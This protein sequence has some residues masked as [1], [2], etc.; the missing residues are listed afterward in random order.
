MGAESTP[1]AA[2]AWPLPDDLDLAALQ[3]RAGLRRLDARFL[4]ELD[5][6]APALAGQLRAARRQAPADARAE[7]ELLIELAG[8]LED[9]LGRL[10]A[11]EPEL[12]ALR[13]R[14]QA[15]DPVLRTKYKF[16]KR[17]ALLGTEPEQ[18][19]AFDAPALRTALIAAGADLADEPAFADALLQW[20]EQ[21][22]KGDDT[23]REVARARIALARDY[24][25]WAAGTEAGRAHH[26]ESVLF[27]HPQ[28]LDPSQRIALAGTHADQR[29][30]IEHR[31]SVHALRERRGFAL[32]DPGF[33]LARALDEARYCLNCPRQGNDSCR[34]GLIRT[35]DAR[36]GDAGEVDGAHDR[37]RPATERGGDAARRAETTIDAP[38]GPRFAR[39]P[40][41]EALRGCPLEERISEFLWLKEHAKPL[42]ALAMIV[43]DNPM[44]AATGHRICNDCSKACVFQQQTPVDIPQ[45]ETRVLRDV[46]ALPWGVELY[47]LLLRWNPL[48]LRQWLPKPAS[49]RRVLVV[50]CGPAGFTLAHELLRAG[51]QVVAIDGLKIEP[52][53][54]D[55]QPIVDAG[56]LREPLDTRVAAGFGG[57][58]EY[59]ITV[60]WDKNYLRLIRRL[61]ERWPRF[62][63]FGG[64]RL[65]STLDLDQAFA[66]G[67]DHVALAVGAGRPTVLDI[68]GGLANGVRAASDFLMALQLTGAAREDSL[69]NLELRLPAVIVGGGLTAI[70]AATEARAYYAVQVEKMLCR[71]EA[72]PQPERLAQRDDPD[73]Q[74]FL[75]H[76]RALRQADALPG[77]QA[78]AARHALIE[79]W[80]GVTI[81]YRRR[82]ADS[83][84]YRLNPE[85]LGHAMAEG[86]RL[87]S[88][89]QPLAIETDARDRVTGLR[90]R[91][92]DGAEKILPAATI[93][94]AAGTHPNTVLARENEPPLPLEAGYLATV[95]GAGPG[96]HPKDPAV[97]FV[98]QRR[99]DGRAVSM[100]GDAHPAF[101]GNVVRAMAS[102]RR[103]APLIDAELRSL[104]P[105]RIRPQ[106]WSRWVARLTRDWQ[107]SVRSVRRL[108]PGIVELT[109]RAPAAAA[110]FAPGQFYRLQTFEAA[111]ELRTLAGQPAR[112]ATETLALTGAWVDAR[113]GTVALVVLEM[114]GT[115]DLIARLRPGQA[116]V[117][118]GP[119]GEP[120]MIGRGETV[121]LV[122]GGLGNAVLF[123]I[124][125]A[126]REAGNRV[127]YVAGYRRPADRFHAP[128]I[129][130]AAEAVIWEANRPPVRTR[131]PGRRRIPGQCRAG[132]RA[133]ATGGFAHLGFTCAMPAPLVIGS[134]RMMAAVARALRGPLAEA[135]SPGLVSIA[136]VN[137]PMQ[138]M[139]KEICGQCLQ[140]QIDPQSG[141]SSTCSAAP[142]R[143]AAGIRGLRLPGRASGPECHPG[144]PVGTLAAPYPGDAD[145]RKP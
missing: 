86:V 33:S 136:S 72:L 1:V 47:G 132:A 116:V 36:P 14:H 22:R 117:L 102:A 9:F 121:V 48:D 23:E 118:M 49:S 2:R 59:G 66:T 139:M 19:R 104:P 87:Q 45:T 97:S 7:S 5:Q 6:S 95:G 39:S 28:P 52:D 115:A 53:P 63:M 75:E 70:D 29:G 110:R 10:F 135:V 84:A 96:Q 99:P 74:V 90:V 44:V 113:A 17:Q 131:A 32:T 106:A 58:A 145:S 108:A 3:T 91:D 18:R 57:V 4:R 134:D 11:I 64:V 12:A 24:A 60:R 77:A 143:P 127:I 30:A 35:P 68:P 21:A 141:R 61:L 123:S 107:A 79:Q 20:Q 103:A 37:A 27:R 89:V 54:H 69:A 8:Q 94:I 73:L 46:L 111:A 78:A 92:L 41:G 129:E 85:E 65:G 105:A 112:L 51:H 80:G 122:G 114:G 38:R 43:L 144:A 31:I 120:T 109:V 100:L 88:G 98:C 119:T 138:C 101:A 76:A 13:A 67:F 93:L 34:R 137:S 26:P 15:Q 16:V 81:A 40:F 83:P 55:G 42:G 142:A 62:R 50:G 125:A 128:R 82:L 130:A 140:R 133:L 126:M 124:G 25:A 71:F 56:C